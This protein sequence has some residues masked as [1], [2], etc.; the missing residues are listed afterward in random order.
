MN[1]RKI[2]A[3]GSGAMGIWD[4]PIAEVMTHPDTEKEHPV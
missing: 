2:L 3:I 1:V 4:S